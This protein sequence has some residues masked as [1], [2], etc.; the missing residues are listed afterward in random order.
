MEPQGSRE[1]PASVPIQSVTRQQVPENRAG[2]TNVIHV[3]MKTINNF[4]TASLYLGVIGIGMIPLAMI[5]EEGAI[6]FFIWLPALLAVIFGH[7]GAN[8]ASKTGIGRLPA[9][10]GCVLGYLVLVLYIIAIVFLML[11]LQELG[12]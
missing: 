12:S 3:Q 4:A 5:S 1:K 2:H 10:T 6:C 11:L 9:I 8:Q 7:I